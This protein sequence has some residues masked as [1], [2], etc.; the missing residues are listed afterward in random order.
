MTLL[1][2]DRDVSLAKAF[3]FAVD[4]AAILLTIEVVFLAQT[5]ALTEARTQVFVEERYPCFS[6]YFL[7]YPTQ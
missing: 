2:F 3:P 6:S 5:A 1:C 4:A 7:S